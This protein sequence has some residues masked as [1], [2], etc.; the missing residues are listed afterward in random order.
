MILRVD[1][2]D[3]WREREVNCL[4]KELEMN[5]GEVWVLGPK[6]MGWL[7][8]GEERLPDKDLRSDQYLERLD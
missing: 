3:L 6:E 5:L 2:L 8:G 4:L 7:G 1:F